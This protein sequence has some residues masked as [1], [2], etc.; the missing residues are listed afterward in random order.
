MA[1]PAK[2]MLGDPVIYH[3]AGEE[4]CRGRIAF[5]IKTHDDDPHL[6]CLVAYCPTS[7]QW[8]EVHDV[9]FGKPYD[10]EGDRDY[11]VNQCCE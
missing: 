11:F 7:H 1:H 6:A 9:K 8:F 4:E 10:G 2:T 5:V 3:K